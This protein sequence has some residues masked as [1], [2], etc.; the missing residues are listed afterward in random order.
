MDFSI[1]LCT[2][3]RSGNLR[4][5]LKD[6]EDLAVPQ[7]VSH[8]IIVVDNNSSDDTKS[9]VEATIRGQPEVF[10]YARESRQGKAFALNTGIGLSRGDI[11]IF[12][13]DDVQIDR[14]WLAEIMR[15]FE[16]YPCMGIGGRIIA[17]W[18]SPKP[19]WFEEGG[20]YQLIPAVV[21]EFDLGD[22]PSEM[23]TGAWGANMAF[24]RA[25]FKKYGLFREDLGR[26]PA[27]L[28]GGE[29]TEFCERLLRGGEQM[30]YIPSAIVYHPV[31]VKRTTRQYFQSWY[32]DNGRTLMRNNAAQNDTTRYFGV[33]RRLFRTHAS[34]CARWLC[35]LDAKRRFYYKLQLYQ[36]AGAILES[37][38]RFA[39]SRR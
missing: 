12:T 37:R 36:N 8:E 18:N 15:S 4:R 17:V 21:V 9:V 20:R 32:F 13:D 19:E 25:A 34:L 38:R 10:R 16:S 33:P 31:D 23:R 26:N 11:L 39:R 7:G 28:I 30:M 24:R 22:Q 29:D 5:V 14:L 2:Y 1:V 27:N 35:T 6:L 3:N